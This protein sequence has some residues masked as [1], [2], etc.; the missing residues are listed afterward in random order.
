MNFLDA[1]NT[2]IGEIEKP[3]LLPRGTYVWKVSKTHKETT[4]GKG[5]WNIVEIPVVP[6]MPYDNADDVDP[7]ELSAFGQLTQGANA[8]RFMFPTDPEK[9][10]DRQKTLWGLRRFLI[11]TLKVE[12]DDDSTI[13]E[14]LAKMVGAEF[15][16]QASHRPDPERNDVFCD[17]KNWAPLD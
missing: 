2:K 17:V 10:V 16:A 7:D 8:I 11:D 14:M 4:P 13:K 9:D 5:E 12:G 6:V 3:P 15:I 1:L